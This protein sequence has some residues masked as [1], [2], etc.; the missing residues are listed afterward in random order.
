MLS[1]FFG[2]LV[3]RVDDAL[4]LK[5]TE[6]AKCQF[7]IAFNRGMDMIKKPFLARDAGFGL[8]FDQFLEIHNRDVK[9]CGDF[10]DD[11]PHLRQYPQRA[12]IFVNSTLKGLFRFRIPA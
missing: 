1:S 4:R 8:R 9:L 11:R 5:F 10:R 6:Q 7:S 3:P 2:P 12:D